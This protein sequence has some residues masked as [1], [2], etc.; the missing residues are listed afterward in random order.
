VVE[1]GQT[2]FLEPLYD[3]NAFDLSL[4]RLILD[5]HLRRA[6]GAR[7][8]AYVRERH[9]LQKNYHELENCL[10]KIVK[11]RQRAA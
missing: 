10:K 5:Q 11:G 6:M 2:G 1:N 7:A 9:D 8:K 3:E 4:K